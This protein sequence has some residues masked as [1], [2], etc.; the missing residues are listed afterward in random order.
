MK[1]QLLLH[2][3]SLLRGARDTIFLLKNEISLSSALQ[4]SNVENTVPTIDNQ[5]QSFSARRP[6][7]SDFSFEMLDISLKMER[8]SSHVSFAAFEH[9]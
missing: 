5:G 3:L 6:C 7:F 2:P 9:D 1:M 8:T 4:Q